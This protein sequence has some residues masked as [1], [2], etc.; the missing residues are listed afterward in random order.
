M[1]SNPKSS[2]HF[3]ELDDLDK[4]C[5]KPCGLLILFYLAKNPS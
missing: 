5:S 2:K 3:E 1:I 4:I